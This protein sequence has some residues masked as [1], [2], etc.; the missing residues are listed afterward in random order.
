MT[1]VLV[2]D[3]ELSIRETFQVFLEDAGYQVS[4]AADFFS[5]EA[6]LTS[7]PCD[8]VVADVILPRVNGL[9]LLELVH[10]IDDSI[11][12]IIITGEPDVATAA[13]AVR[14][15]AYDYL[16]KPVTH[17]ALLGVVGR[18]AE[19]KRLLDE[20]RRLEAEN[21]AYQLELERM[22]AQR[23]AELAQRNRELT[24]LI[25]I[26]RDISGILNLTEVLKQVTRRTAQ[27]CGAHRCSIL[28][29]AGDGKTLIPLMSQFSN[30][31]SDETLWQKFVN[32]AWPTTLDRLPEWEQLTR[33]QRPLF[34][35]EAS[36]TSLPEQ[37]LQ[38]FG[39]RS[40]LLV[41][42][43]A[44]GEVIG[45]MVLDQV[46][47]DKGFTAAQI[48]L[49]AAIGAQ[50]A[51]AIDNARLFEAEQHRRQEAETLY[52]ATQAL[53]TT[54]DLDQ[55][56]ERILSELQQVVPYDS[57]SIQLLR[58]DGC[59]EIIGG[60]GFSNPDEIIGL[61]FDTSKGDNPNRE[62]VCHHAPLIVDNA[63]ALYPAFRA[64]PHASAGI[65]SWMGVP[66]MFGDRLIGLLSLDKRE[67]GFYTQE[68][69]RL[70]EAF[71]A[72]A[73]IA[74]EN[75]RLYNEVRRSAEEMTTLYHISLE[76]GG[77]T[78]LSDLLWTICDR[79]A[80]LINVD[81]GGLYLY[82]P[83]R[84][85]L[86]LAVAYKL[87][88][89]FIGTRLKLGEG[90][91]G[92]VVQTGQPLIVDDYSHWEG[93]AR[94]YEGEQFTTVIGVPLKWKE[95]IIGAMTLSGEAEERVFTAEDERLLSLFAQQ[96]A[97]AIENSRLYHE[98]KRLV[99]ELTVLHNIDIAIT[100]TLELDKLLEIVY[101]QVDQA[102]HPTAFYIG[103][104]N[105]DRDELNVLLT[106]EN[107]QRLPPLTLKVEETRGLSS[108][109]IRTGQPLWIDDLEAEQTA[110]PVEAITIGQPARA[111]MLLPLISK[112]KT[113]GVISA[114]SDRPHAFDEGHR[115]LFSGIAS[116]VAIALENVVL[117]EETRRRLAETRL[118]QELMH[119]TAS[120]LDFDEVLA[121]AME[122]LRRELHLDQ[123][124]FTVPNED[125]TALYVHSSLRGPDVVPPGLAVP[126]ERSVS[127]V[128][129]RTGKPQ[130]IPDV[131]EVPYFFEV[132]PGIRSELTV[133][134]KV[135]DRVVA[136]LDI[137]SYRPHAFDQDDLNLF[138]AIASQLG[139][140]LENA[141]LYKETSRRLAEAVLIQEVMLAASSTLDLDLVIE[142]TVKAL[143]RALNIEEV[144]LLLPDEQSKFLVFYSPSTG[145]QGQ[146]EVTKLPIEDS[147]AGQVYLTGQPVLLRDVAAQRE[148]L[149]KQFTFD[150]TVRSFLAVPVQ[151]G[152]NI[153]AVLQAESRTP[154]AFGE[155]EL[156]VFTTI[157]GQ[158][159]VV[160][161]NARLYKK[162][163]A[164]TTELLRAYRELQEVT[165]LRTE[166]VQNVSHELRTPLSLIQGY[167][168]LLLEGDLGPLPQKQQKVLQTIRERAAGLARSIHNLT[169]LQNMPRLILERTQVSLVDLLHSAVS[170]FQVLAERSGIVFQE[171]L[172][173]DL[174]VIWADRERMEL[175]FSH[176]IENAI[177]FS[178]HG[179]TVS[180]HAWAD[181]H[182]VYVSV[183]DEGIGI[184]QD[185]LHLIFERFYQVDGSASRRFGGMGVGLAL[186]W[187]IVEAHGGTV[188]VES[189]VGKGSNFTVA[190]P[191]TN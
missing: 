60:R 151:S 77:F 142:R 177:K 180:I 95:R 17:K 96:A 183:R 76:M 23:T 85:E 22:V 100:S 131:R 30:G 74:I 27:A 75:S 2:V 126:L 107:G 140:A 135:A 101:E 52:R 113:I 86:E 38:P 179:G 166:L 106:V 123:L 4:T 64:E 104:Y 109:V 143:H 94:V 102:M 36:S 57:A 110:L 49:A 118:L 26:G 103:L 71:A 119:T 31:H 150:P 79:A 33:E 185:R 53:T 144:A 90:V 162:L 105:A 186:V 58:E 139:V 132:T 89:D 59:L 149:A 6:L 133:P 170:G 174:P 129:Y 112:G 65:L 158:L 14:R 188:T 169:M 114:Q 11:P 8:I 167:T 111:A 24:A 164:Q 63:P 182:W 128:V 39:V 154:G 115:R 181:E 136:I 175:V 44:K 51:I 32:L 148:T 16:A 10:R 35:P 156:R 146:A 73:A 21:R 153:T 87:R 176:L 81:K 155:D 25:E 84:Q 189:E 138:L 121:R 66:L 28:L 19:K 99:D 41:P 1:H 178:P 40:L 98:A 141:R 159:G 172:A 29:L 48:E 62:V 97:L 50:A 72:Q 171:H 187:E 168:E 47:A 18:A 83:R 117:F 163:E 147:P 5:A 145:K 3:D 91:A 88:G 160:L 122:I 13:E 116:Q 45:V 161:E 173:D 67:A 130:L 69:A 42:L 55:I 125:G 61:R 157:A 78:E 134:V 165:R 120:T 92:R 20:K 80:R 93:R 190:L 46:E 9:E 124:T 56:F 82:D 137:E 54:L 34:L 43:V 7:Q 108:W 37:W 15:G 152:P 70:A 12:V 184:P 191:R 68:H 127:G